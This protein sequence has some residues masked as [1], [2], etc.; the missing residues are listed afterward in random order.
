MKKSDNVFYEHVLDSL[1][2]LSSLE[3]QKKR[4]L[5][6]SDELSSPVEAIVLLYDDS[7]LEDALKNKTCCLPDEIIADLVVFENTIDCLD[8]CQSL[9]ELI[10]G[11]AMTPVRAQAKSLHQRIRLWCATTALHLRK[12][13]RADDTSSI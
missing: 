9:T 5:A 12:I 13:G 2:E 4:W 6:E 7:G 1:E 11:T 8:L 10:E 3:L